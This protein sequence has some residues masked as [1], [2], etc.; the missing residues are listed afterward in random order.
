MSH[1]GETASLAAWLDA[2]ADGASVKDWIE[3]TEPNLSFH[4]TRQDGRTVG[5][6]VAFMLEAAPPWGQQG[7]DR[8]LATTL[9]FFLTREQLQLAASTVREALLRFPSRGRGASRKF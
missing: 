2:I 1:G 7:G 9:S 4:R 5:V 8:D 3:F 6:E